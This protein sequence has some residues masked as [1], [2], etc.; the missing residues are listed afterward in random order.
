MNQYNIWN[1][2]QSQPSN[3]YGWYDSQPPQQQQQGGQQQQQGGGGGQGVGSD[4]LSPDLLINKLNNL[5]SSS[6]YNHFLQ[7]LDPNQG[8]NGSP[9]NS[10]YHYQSQNSLNFIDHQPSYNNINNNT[11][12]LPLELQGGISNINSRRPSFT[13]EQ[14][15]TQT[16]QSIPKNNLNLLAHSNNFNNFYNNTSGQNNQLLQNFRSRRPSIQI[17]GSGNIPATAPSPSMNLPSVTGAGNDG[18]ELDNGLILNG[19]F[20]ITS[21][22]LRLEFQKTQNYFC[23]ES[24]DHFYKNLINQIET[25]EYLKKIIINLKKLN[26]LFNLI[27]PLVLVLTKSGKFEILS[28][29]INSNIYLN[30]HDVV[31][32]DGDRGKDLVLI[33]DPSIS[34]DVAI[35]INYLKK[36]QHLKSMSYGGTNGTSTNG[37]TTTIS[38]T[39]EDLIKG[40]GILDEETQFQIPSKQVLRFAT[41]QEINNLKF[42]LIEE[43][44]SYKTSILKISNLLNL[45]NNLTILNSEYQFDQKKLTF[46]YFANQRLDFRNLIKELFKIYKTRIWLCAVP[47]PPFYDPQTINSTNGLNMDL[48]EINFQDFKIDDFHVRN[49]NITLNELMEN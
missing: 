34:L 12:Q 44:K 18:L 6:N 36:R 31:I 11:F 48:N 24:A 49:F 30:K 3:H 21:N 47:K 43:I 46:Y 37:S 33:L 23:L 16:Q 38:N 20:I 1:N 35:L 42:K 14:S 10:N 22:Q 4:Q 39:K 9:N 7:S 45:N 26:N 40:Q 8:S 2:Q 13:A 25:N 41:G 15:Y 28:T 17:N 19:N 5:S 32:V 27:K 29:P